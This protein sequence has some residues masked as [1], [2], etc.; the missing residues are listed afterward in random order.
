MR[1]ALVTYKSFRRIPDC[2]VRP[3]PLES[4]RTAAAGSARGAEVREQEEAVLRPIP[5]RRALTHAPPGVVFVLTLP[6]I[7]GTALAARLTAQEP[8]TAAGERVSLDPRPMAAADP[9]IDR[10]LAEIERLAEASGGTVGVGALHLESGRRAFFNPDERFPMASTYKVPIA[11]QLLTRVD[12][13][14]ISLD[15]MVTLEPQDVHPG[16]GTISRLLDDP[17]VALS[18]RNLLELMLLISDNSATDLCLA[19]AGGPEAVNARM[20]ELGVDGLSVDRPT[21]IL[22]ADYVGVEGTPPDGRIS[23]ERFRELAGQV[24]DEER[25]EAA[26]AFASDAR[27]T[28][29]PVA[30]T[31]LLEAIWTGRALSPES[32]TLLRDILLRVE[33]G[34]GRIRGRL[35]PGTQVGHKTGTIGGATNDVG[36]IYLPGDAGHVVTVVFVR[37]SERGV[38]A[39]EAVIAEISRAIYD[40][41][42]FNPPPAG[43]GGR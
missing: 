9:A 41:F 31:Q 24:G 43:S 34:Q 6:L 12:R 42:L 23:I 40:F 7:V 28:S 19:A 29:T 17:G 18:L 1:L 20:A 38:P 21:S 5:T 25:E 35:P 36:Y 33:T 22:I 32:T 26:S 13:G 8:A 39:R 3:E 30:M 16:S 2:R 11:V 15:D 10:L 14:E 4:L 37:D 27:D